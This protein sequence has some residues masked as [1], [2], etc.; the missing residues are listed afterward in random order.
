MNNAHPTQLPLFLTVRQAAEEIQVQP[1]TIY[2]WIKNQCLRA[3]KLPGGIEIRIRRA[4]WEIFLNSMF[5]E[6]DQ[7]NA[8]TDSFQQLPSTGNENE[9]EGRNHPPSTSIR[10]QRGQKRDFFELGLHGPSITRH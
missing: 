1:K 9:A 8:S 10:A 5:T 2:A 3:G 7:I 6:D 4:D